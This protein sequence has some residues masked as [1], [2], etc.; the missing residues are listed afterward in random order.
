M[1]EG[2]S[3][4]VSGAESPDAGEL[5]AELARLASLTWKLDTVPLAVHRQIVELLERTDAVLRKLETQQ[6]QAKGA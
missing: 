4:A 3:G 6:Q 1:P 2:L 5:A